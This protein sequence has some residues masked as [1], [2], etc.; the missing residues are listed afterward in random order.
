MHCRM[1]SS[2]AGLY[3]LDASGLH[4]HVTHQMSTAPVPGTYECVRSHGPGN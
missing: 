1:L 2:I 4:N 3:P